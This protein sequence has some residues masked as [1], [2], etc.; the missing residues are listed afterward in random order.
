MSGDGR[1]AA[2]KMLCSLGVSTIYEAAGRRGG[3]DPDIRPIASGMRVCGPVFTAACHPG[4]NLAAHR[5]LAVAP[6][7][8]VL[9]V[10]GAGVFVGYWGELMT[11]AAQARGIAGLVIDGAVRDVAVLVE[12]AFPVW[13]R[14]VSMRGAAKE[15]AGVIGAPVV[16][17]G[18]AAAPGDW[19]V[20]DDDGVVC[21]AA[22]ELERVASA[23]LARTRRE[24]ELAERLRSGETTIDALGLRDA[25]VRQ[26]VADQATRVTR[27]S[28]R[29]RPTGTGAAPGPSGRRSSRAP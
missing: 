20:G 28:A 7:G 25:L 2:A 16:C 1:G 24:A 10:A 5:A 12:R 11:I 4:D 26:G 22:A 9:V 21:V 14:G 19:V 27:Q 6:A 17:G 3:M 29:S 8:S 13:A 23:A 18:I 15:T